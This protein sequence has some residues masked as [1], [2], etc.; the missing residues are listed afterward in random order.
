MR[1]NKL[2]FK[3]ILVCLSLANLAYLPWWV[4][5]LY[6]GIDSF[7]Y[8]QPSEH[9]IDSTY[10]KALSLAVP[11]VACFIYLGLKVFRN[12][13]NFAL[14]CVLCTLTLFLLTLAA[15]GLRLS[16]GLT[17]HVL[18]LSFGWITIWS[19]IGVGMALVLYLLIYNRKALLKLTYLSLLLLSPFI[20]VTYSLSFYKLQQIA[21]LDNLNEPQAP[22]LLNT[23]RQPKVVWVVFDDLDHR[24][25]FEHRPA[26]LVLE[27]LDR[28]KA[29][30]LYATKAQAAAEKTVMAIPA[31]TTG[32]I[33]KSAKVI[34]SHHLA[35]EIDGQ[36]YTSLWNEMPTLFSKAYKQGFNNG[37]VGFFHPYKRILGHDLA[38]C[39]GDCNDAMQPKKSFGRTYLE[40]LMLWEGVP[41]M[42]F[43]GK[44]KSHI[45]IEK[46]RDIHLNTYTHLL[47][48]TQEA[49]KKRELDLTFIHL[50]IPHLPV[51]YDTKEK[52]LS[53]THH[54]LKGYQE[55]LQLVDETL[56]AIREELE[57]SGDWQR[58]FLIVTSDHGL[59]KERW[60][61][62]SVF[63]I[64]SEVLE[65]IKTND[66]Q[67][68]FMVRFPHQKNPL[69]YEKPFSSL[70][71]S[72]IILHLLNGKIQTAEELA[73]WLDWRTYPSHPKN[74]NLDLP[75]ANFSSSLGVSETSESKMRLMPQRMKNLDVC[76]L[77]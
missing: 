50:P 67:I 33:V 40:L 20:L 30:S 48:Q 4:E 8:Y 54:S 15:N 74:A 35:L 55:N 77:S 13:T 43:D 3:D 25:A 66:G 61:P 46:R 72:D 58:T 49:L 23:P 18:V 60:G 42:T 24:V 31:L 7:Y 62:K 11:T 76:T 28:L 57:R 12:T 56:K 68:P 39:P 14:K 6:R 32:K 73:D 38:F 45:Q 65:L 63:S 22:T 41:F 47:N 10:I 52:K 34:N 75:K 51:I 59:H 5:Y 70:L 71:V 64:E 27:E 21:A 36:D 29:E 19:L 53:S 16:A 9:L 17:K 1:I 44:E 26:G 2:F 69:R 37:L